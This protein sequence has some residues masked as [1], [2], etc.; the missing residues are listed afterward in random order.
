MKPTRWED[1]I[2]H[3]ASMSAEFVSSY[4]DKTRKVLLIAAAGFDPRSGLVARRLAESKVA[5]RAIFIREER[6]NADTVLRERADENQTGLAH[7][8]PD[9][10]IVPIDV[11]DPDDGAVVG[12]KNL[13]VAVRDRLGTDWTDIVID[14]SALS[15]GMSFPLVRAFVE[16][17]DAAE[18]PW[19]VHLFVTSN[20]ELDQRIRSEHADIPIYVPGFDG[21][22]E[23]SD[24]ADAT[25]LWVPQ[26]VS[27]KKDSLR[28][29]H[30]F[31]GAHETCPILP[32]PSKNPR[33][34]DELIE[35]FVTFL[36]SAWEVD[37]RNYIYTAEEE[38]LDLYRTLLRLSIARDKVYREHGGSLMILSPVGSKVTA[39]GALMAAIEGNF[40][41]VYLETLSYQADKEQLKPRF[42]EDE[43]PIHIWLTGTPYRSNG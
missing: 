7:L 10:E 32:F 29:I 20:P 30:E 38:P 11:F 5:C 41:V 33:R 27:G 2:F 15:I 3:P 8:F 25:K 14:M 28:R 18:E 6:P 34:G 22:A 40:P 43:Q 12:G 23:L 13:W 24:Q 21:G 26:L 31:L 17:S 37:P 39:I 4:M 9:H 35:E 16:S 36:A 1:C 19:N 42:H